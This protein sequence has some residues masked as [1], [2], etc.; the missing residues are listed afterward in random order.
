MGVP[1]TG[2]FQAPQGQAAS[3]YYLIVA[4]SFV[5]LTCRAVSRDIVLQTAGDVSQ[6]LAVDS[7]AAGS[8]RALVFGRFP[9]ETE[10]DTSGFRP[11]ASIACACADPIALELGLMRRA[12]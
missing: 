10:F 6:R 12:A 9:L 2:Q 8:P 1:A 4:S 5:W 3:S 11:L 7:R